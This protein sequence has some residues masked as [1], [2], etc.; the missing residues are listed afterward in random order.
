VLHRTAD[1]AKH[2]RVS[3]LAAGVAFYLFLALVP[4]IALAVSV[5]GLVASPSDIRSF[6]QDSLSAAPRE[7][8]D[9]V[10]AQ[11]EKVSRSGNAETGLGAV[12]AGLLALWSASSGMNQLVGALNVAFDEED[13]R[14]FVRKRALALLLTMGA[15]VFGAVAIALIAVLPSALADTELGRPARWTIGVLRWPVLALGMLGALAVLYRIAPDREDARWKWVTPGAAVAVVVWL[16]GSALFSIYAA[17]FGRFQATYGSLASIVVMLLWLL[18]TA[19]VV[20]LGAEL[21]AELER[22]TVKDTTTGPSRRLGERDAYAAD[23][24]GPSA[25][26]RRPMGPSR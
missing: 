19:Y 25:G 6:A 16:A 2:D 13:R 5:Y 9:L 7:V 12:L 11:L 8:R 10:T 21:D 1:E 14:K 15:V 24:V 4:A 22:Q 26:E 18:L 3:L 17:N 20:I 23:T